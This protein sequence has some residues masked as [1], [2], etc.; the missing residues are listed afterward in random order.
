V[1]ASGTSRANF[2]F[3]AKLYNQNF[4]KRLP[5]DFAAFHFAKCA[6]NKEIQRLAEVFGVSA[7]ELLK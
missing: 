1:S 2:A 5:C 3:S 6:T 4:S 7:A